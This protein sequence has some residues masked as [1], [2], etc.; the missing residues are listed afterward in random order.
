[1]GEPAYL[2]ESVFGPDWPNLP[3]A[4]KRRY[5]ARSDGSNEVTVEGKLDI[6]GSR[7][8][9]LLKP[10]LLFFG[11]LVPYEG[12][13]V[14]VTVRFR[15]E[16]GLLNFDRSFA[17]PGREPF[18]FR[19]RIETRRD[20][21]TVEYMRFNLGWR[22]QYRFDGQKIRIT[23]RGYVLK[24]FGCLQP[25]PL[26]LVMGKGYGEEWAEGDD[27]FGM[28]IELNHFLWGRTFGYHGSFRVL[29]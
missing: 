7:L 21:D 5:A 10:F 26:S 17:F 2:F 15:A 25:L 22:G 28:M 24:I 14:P 12:E 9:R 18:R 8:S 27:S 3:P 20:G 13:N 6:K 4:L 29:P 1:M 19:S 16:N 23:H 11:A